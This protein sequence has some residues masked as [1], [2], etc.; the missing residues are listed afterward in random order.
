M[1]ALEYFQV[2]SPE[3]VGAEYY[4]KIIGTVL[5]DLD[6][7]KIISKLHVFVDPKIPIFVAVGIIKK[8]PSLIRVRDT[9]A[10][11][12]EDHK[13]VIS[14]GDETYLAPLLSVLQ[15][16]FGKDHVEQPDRFTVLITAEE[17][18]GSDIEEMVVADPSESIYRDLVYAL[19]YAAPEGFKVR[20]QY[21]G[22]D[23]FYYVASEDTLD[24]TMVRN[25]V[26]EKFSLIGVAYDI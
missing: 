22:K 21:V 12:P 5:Q 8:L 18:I 1:D 2:E 14:I 9:G 7:I 17:A 23:R 19:Q 6:L 13:A 3:P 16:K 26:R 4:R 10:V 24:D 25:M 11:K 20:R 15:A